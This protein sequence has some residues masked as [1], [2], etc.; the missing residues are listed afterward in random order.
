ML[1]SHLFKLDD[2][3]TVASCAILQSIP[4][5]YDMSRQLT[6]QEVDIWVHRANLR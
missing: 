6:Y 4:E 3:R 5:V 1:F 2:L